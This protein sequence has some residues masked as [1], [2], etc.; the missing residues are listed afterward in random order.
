MM[1]GFLEV[2]KAK[3]LSNLAQIY[4]VR[5]VT[6]PAFGMRAADVPPISSVSKFSNTSRS[7]FIH[8]GVIQ[9]TN[10]LSPP[11]SFTMSVPVL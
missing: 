1:H 8:S 6:D 3:L 9:D 2:A 7:R 11:C 4:A 10:P 5:L